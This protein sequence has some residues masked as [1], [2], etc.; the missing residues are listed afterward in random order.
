M[1]PL[2]ETY[3]QWEHCT[4]LTSFGTVAS[5]EKQVPSP[6]FAWLHLLLPACQVRNDCSCFLQHPVVCSP[7][8]AL[9]SSRPLFMFEEHHS[10]PLTTTLFQLRPLSFCY[11]ATLILLYPFSSILFLSSGHKIVKSCVKESV[12]SGQNS[13]QMC[14][15]FLWACLWI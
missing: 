6:S 11:L 3:Q 10:Q 4:L 2:C 5:W 7:P 9:P 12:K 1:V 15:F 14:F 8:V 13:R